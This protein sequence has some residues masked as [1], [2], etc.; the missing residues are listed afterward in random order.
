MPIKRSPRVKIRRGILNRGS[1]SYANIQQCKN[2][3]IRVSPLPAK[4]KRA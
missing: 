3:V 1:G 4:K 2:D